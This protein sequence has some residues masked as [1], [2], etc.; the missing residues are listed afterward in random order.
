MSII[1]DLITLIRILFA[2][3]F[4]QVWEAWMRICTTLRD[5]SNIT[6]STRFRNRSFRSFYGRV[7]QNVRGKP[8]F[9]KKFDGSCGRFHTLNHI[10]N[11]CVL[12][13]HIFINQYHTEMGR[14]DNKYPESDNYKNQN[15]F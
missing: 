3:F 8:A 7:L 12:I 5:Q 4:V 6:G 9:G 1:Y 15:T 14:L 10:V 11:D 2:Y 13:D